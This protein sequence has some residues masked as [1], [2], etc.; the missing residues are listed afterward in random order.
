[1]GGETTYECGRCG[2]T[3]SATADHTEIV[4]R[5]FVRVPQPSRIERLCRDC[6]TDYIEEFLGRDIDDVRA[7]YDAAES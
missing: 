5:D 1:M 4:R 2:A 3:F 6:W 7:R